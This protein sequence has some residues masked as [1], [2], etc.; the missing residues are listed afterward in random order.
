MSQ[1]D[2]QRIRKHAAGAGTSRAP[3]SSD[4]SM[5]DA[6]RR[7][8]GSSLYQLRATSRERQREARAAAPDEGQP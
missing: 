8:L 5:D 3:T 4:S 1:K 6:I 2:R 7:Y